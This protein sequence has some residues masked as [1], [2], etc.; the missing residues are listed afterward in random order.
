MTILHAKR[1]SDIRNAFSTRANIKKY[2]SENGTSFSLKR[3]PKDLRP[4]LTRAL[5]KKI[6]KNLKYKLLPK[7]IKKKNAFP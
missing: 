3:L 2:N 1:R 6:T 7:Q 4:R 5:R